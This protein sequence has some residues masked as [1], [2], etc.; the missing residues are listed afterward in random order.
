MKR[1]LFLLVLIV[2]LSLV[3]I[4]GFK[5]IP[6]KEREELLYF[7][8]NKLVKALTAG[9]DLLLADLFWIE[10]GT[11]FGK[12]RR[13]DESYPYLYHMLDITTDLDSRFIPVY[14][15][16]AM[17]LT[18]DAKQMDLA[19]KL[20]DKGMNNNPKLWHIPFTKGFIH[21]I[22]NK[23]YDEA[24]KWFL[25][26]SYKKD[27]PERVLKFA[28]W[29]LSKGKGVEVTL[30]LYLRLYQVSSSEILRGKAIKGIEK[31][32]S[33]QL[34]R[35]NEDKGYLPN[36]LFTLVKSGYLPFVPR[37]PEGVFKIKN[38]EVIFRQFQ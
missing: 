21:Y 13:S 7:P 22:Y 8:S 14:T 37:I 10:T 30:N 1:I 36:S 34:K 9:F 12:H 2:L 3:E 19:F 6:K 31:T 28:T 20:L 24:S 25:L 5:W 33:D 11:Y 35:F 17:L 15:I 29:T 27:A 16:G 23:D 38:D 18:D 32:L 26:A 4:R